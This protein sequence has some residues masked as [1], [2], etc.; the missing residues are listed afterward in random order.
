MSIQES[1]SVDAGSA[2]HRAIVIDNTS[3]RF[4]ARSGQKSQPRRDA[5]LFR[6]RLDVS[7]ILKIEYRA[8]DGRQ[9]PMARQLRTTVAR[10]F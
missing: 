4:I 9:N 8:L 5:P 10:R 3:T 7:A 2:A 6:R 1:K